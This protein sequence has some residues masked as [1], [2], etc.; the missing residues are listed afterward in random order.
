VSQL[1]F[2]IGLFLIT[3]CT[4]ML[5]V[6]QTRILSVVTWYHLAFFSISMALFGLTAGAVWVYVRRDRF[7]EK[8]FSF[9]LTHYSAAFA[10]TTA[11]CFM[12]QMT[13]APVV[14]YSVNSVWTWVELALCLAIPFVFSGIVVSIAL[15]RSPFPIGRVYGVD[16]VGAAAG[17]LGVLFVLDH[18]DP[19]SA[20]LWTSVIAAAGALCFAGSVVGT[21]PKMVPPF[22]AFFRHRKTIFVVLFVCAIFNGLTDYGFQPL[23]VKG[24]FEGPK[25]HIFLEWNSFSRIA[26]YPMEATTPYLWGPS[27]RFSIEDFT[28]EQRRLHID[29]DAGTVATRFTGNLK[30]VEFLKYDVTNLAYHLPG[31]ERAAIIG[32]GGGRDILS[33]AVFGYRDIVG[34]EVNPIFVKLLTEEQDFADFTNITQLE[35]VKLVVDEG[36]S[37]FLQTGKTFDVI[38]MT[39]V[40]TWAATGAGAFSLSENGLYTVEAWKIFLNRLSPQGVFTVSRWFTQN[41]PEETARML[42]LAVAA[43][44]ELG[45]PEPERHVF[46]ATSNNIATLIVARQ[47]FSP[48]DLTALNETISLYQYKVFVHPSAES[49]F[50]MFESIVTAK[51]REELEEYTS[52]QEFD[53]TPATD[54][55]PFFF[56]QLPLNKPFEALSVGKSLVGQGTEPGGVRY[57]NLVATAT[58]LVLFVMSMVLVLLTIVMPLRGAIR[59]TGRKLVVGGT[60]YFLLIGIGFM[61]VEIGLLQRMSIFLG[62]SVSLSVVLFTLILSSGVGSLLS[63]IFIIDRGWKFA[64]WSLMTGGYLIALPYWLPDVLLTFGSNSLSHRAILCVATIAPAGLLMGFGFPTGMRLV[65]A[66]DR[67]P[68]PWF[69]GISGAAGVLASVVAVSTSIAFGISTTL[70]MGAICYFLLLPVILTSVWAP[71]LKSTH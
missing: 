4:L 50:E 6:I 42:S 48:N 30:D 60:L 57:G 65:S 5:Q 32:V 59:N 26:V 51:G 7:T 53:L 61:V 39:L 23:V 12:I 56:N 63:D 13:L 70:T 44:L 27:P 25:N 16:L 9:D 62:H 47:P 36:R 67:T 15:T 19:P 46:L 49:S 11:L 68:M 2:Y 20:I 52:S 35:G 34:I 41:E 64:T 66:I 22:H 45:I 43:L 18:I 3:S 58:L 33:A 54:D 14:W 21:V 71:D 37:W 28:I 40:D 17:C 8:T 38:Q 69:W 1:A 29:G 24:R 55:R 10:V 31:R